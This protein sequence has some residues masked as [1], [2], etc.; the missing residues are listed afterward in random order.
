M[1]E[2]IGVANSRSGVNTE[3]ARCPDDGD[4]PLFSIVIPVY[5]AQRSNRDYLRD[6]LDSIAGQTYDGFELIVVDDGS[7]DDTP[8]V[9]QSWTEHHG[10]L[11]VTTLHKT[12]GGQSS[13]RNLGASRARGTWLAFLDQDDL[14]VPERLES[15]LPLLTDDVDLVYSDADTIDAIGQLEHARIHA[16][17]GA[18]GSHPKFS[19]EDALYSDVFVMPGV[20][21]IRKDAFDRINGFDP[22]LSGYEDDDLF[23][24]ALTTSRIAYCPRALLR[25]RMYADNYSRSGRMVSSRTKYWRKLMREYADDGRAAQRARRITLRFLHG[26]LT[27]CEIFID[28]DPALASQNFHAALELLPFV[29]RV[30]RCAFS[31]TGW[32]WTDHRQIARYAR[33]WFINGLEKAT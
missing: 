6:A 3:G 8:G 2:D 18:G 21:T 27:Q 31:L 16:K 12:N 11:V 17:L 15:V 20:M 23:L 13:A 9:V 29:G 7:T 33:W 22:D 5:N 28:E 10:E 1:R 25:W 30:D 19:I 4:K 14:W 24:R 26:F 32:A